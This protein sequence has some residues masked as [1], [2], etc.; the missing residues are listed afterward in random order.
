M[1]SPRTAGLARRSPH[2]FLIPMLSAAVLLACLG[3]AAAHA[4]QC[5]AQVWADEFNGT[6]VDSSKWEFMIGTGTNYGL[7][8][9]WG[10]NELQ[11]YRSQN[12]T[13]D[14][15]R[16]LI[17]AREQRYRGKDY[18]SARLRTLNKG[19]W[20]FGRFEAQI[21][22][23]VGQGIWPAFWMMPTDNVYGGWPQ[24]GEV[25]IMENIGSEPSTV[26]GTIHFGDPYPNNQSSG[27]SF[28]LPGG[29]RFTDGFHTF[30][31]EK[32]AGVIRWMVDD[33][34]YSTKTPADTAGYTWP[35]DERF[36]F[37]LN[38][39]VG[40]DWPGPP[41]ATTVFPQTLEVEYV[42][43]YDGNHP[44]LTGD[45]TVENMEGGVVYSVGN[46]FAGSSFSWT[47][48][49]GATIVS[50]QGTSSIT[51]DWGATGGDV[52]VA[53]TSS[54]GNDQIAMP[55]SV[56]P[57]Y[58][59][60][61]TF[62]NFD[63]PAN[64]TYQTSTGTLVEIANPDPSGVNTSAQ[65]GQYTRD[66]GQQFDT[67]FY[68]VSVITDASQYV[69]GQ[70][71]FYMDVYTAAP[72]GTEILIQLEDSAITTPTNFPDGRHSRYRAF[73]SVQNSWERLAFSL[74]DTPDPNVSDAAIDDI[75]ILFATNSFTGD[76]FTFDNF[77][78]YALDTGGNPPA[79]PSSLGATAVSSS[80]IDLAWSDN[81]TDEDG[82]KI[83]RQTGGAGFAEIATAGAD[84]TAYSD[85]GLAASTGYD[86]RVRAFNVHGNSAFSNTA[87]ATTQGG[88]NPTTM[89]VAA[90]A[91]GTQ[92]AGRGNKRGTATVAIE[93][94]LGNAVAS[95]S[96][97]G[98]FTGDYSETHMGVTDAGGSVTLVTNATQKGGVSFTFCVD[99]VTHGTLSYDPASNVQDCASQ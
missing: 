66:S 68:D 79:A 16:L 65:S 29:Q 92:S 98:T 44:H 89:H 25:D 75:V 46:A 50:G 93:D 85:T 78:S 7:P 55:V 38:V 14:N 82:F 36:H 72:A 58:A 99:D 73:T 70:K 6:S 1:S 10:N 33:V 22:M 52:T 45:R 95:A 11:Y 18:T 48:P 3:P 40:G 15:G 39:A 47:V 63:D 56:N 94:N 88:G 91:V 86:Y 32:E 28:T 64:V 5:P 81:S 42:R 13:V 2:G 53:Y 74:L 67:L 59:H 24:S 62:E 60:D 71:R 4:Q 69:S 41:D 27:A 34:L 87:S 21:K 77:D 9:G 76:V 96:V 84:V 26:H 54:C 30:A 23:T 57:A 8:P 51:V 17:T 80:Q 83:E 20:T 19:D 43:V 97:T 61:F 31:V 90:I 49:A 37:L 12:A 35:F